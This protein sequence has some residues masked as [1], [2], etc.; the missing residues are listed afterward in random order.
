[1]DSCNGKVQGQV[2]AGMAGSRYARNGNRLGHCM[3]LLVCALHVHTQPTLHSQNHAL[4]HELHPLRK[5]NLF[6]FTQSVCWFTNMGV[7]WVKSE[8]GPYTEG[9]E[10]RKKEVGHC[11]MGR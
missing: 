11:Q 1:M 5:K 4:W 6:S 2:A 8:I 7:S 3:R 10:R 9:K